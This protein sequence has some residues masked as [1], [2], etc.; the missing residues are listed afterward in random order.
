MVSRVFD[1]VDG[2]SVPL[3]ESVPY[4]STAPSPPP[5]ICGSYTFPSSAFHPSFSVWTSFLFITSFPAHFTLRTRCLLFAQCRWLICPAGPSGLS[6]RL[7]SLFFRINLVVHS[8]PL[9]NIFKERK[10]TSLKVQDYVRV[11]VRVRVLFQ[12]SDYRHKTVWKQ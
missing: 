12:L 11:N 8:S 9:Y 2:F 7:C 1:N 5:F 10:L 6:V 4:S 3:I